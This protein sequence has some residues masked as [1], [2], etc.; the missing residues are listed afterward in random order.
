MNA[1]DPQECIM[2]SCRR[3]R[4]DPVS[5]HAILQAMDG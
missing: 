2:S 5:S 1:A 4:A 3:S